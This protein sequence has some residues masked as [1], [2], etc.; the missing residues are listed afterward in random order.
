MMATRAFAMLVALMLAT[1]PLRVAGANP[2][3]SVPFVLHDDPAILT[4]TS[5]VPRGAL[6]LAPLVR[7]HATLAELSGLAWDAD[8][9]VLIGVTDR[10]WL[11]SL[12]PLFAGGQLRD[13]KFGGATRLKGANGKR[14]RGVASDAE[15]LVGLKTRNG[16]RGDSEFVVAYER[17]NRLQIHAPDGH[18]KRR[19]TIAAR[20]RDSN[21]FRSPNKG[22]EAVMQHPYAGLVP[23]TEWP[24]ENSD[25]M[26][27]EWYRAD[28]RSVQVAR[29]NRPSAGLVALEALPDGRVLMLERAHSWLGLSLVIELSLIDA[30]DAA[31]TSG[32]L[33]NKQAVWRLDSS[34]GWRV[35]NFE[36]LT[37]HEGMRFLMASDDNGSALQTTLL[38]YFEVKP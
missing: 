24:L 25:D 17:N 12:K 7:R 18:L 1:G 14:L 4:G 22:F 38:V 27:W 35:D 6:D 23:G 33:L 19:V 31:R 21:A 36:A 32:S 3:T 9:Q 15:G 30:W 20:L 10:G 8:E 37:R 5:V 2:V 34:L 11:V 16:I 29:L 28:G 13:V 26:L